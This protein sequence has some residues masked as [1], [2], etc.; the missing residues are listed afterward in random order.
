MKILLLSLL[1]LFITATP[2]QAHVL[3]TDGTI[4]AV[5]HVE[6]EDDPIAGAQ[7]SFFFEFKDKQNKFKPENC[8]C[9][10][11][12]KE[13]NTVI[14][15][16]PLFQNTNNASLNDDDASVSFSFPKR[17]IYEISVVG[18]PN[19]PG[20]F[21]PF[22]LKYTIRVERTAAATTPAPQSWITIHLVQLIGGVLVLGFLIWFLL[23][24]KKKS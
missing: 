9:T 18:K 12:I 1:F 8:D 24:K 22:N 7:S 13:N 16:Q 5:L 6:P 3:I 19:T 10:V 17:A 2:A 20:A 23:R 4:G 21:Q 14:F 11:T 15:T